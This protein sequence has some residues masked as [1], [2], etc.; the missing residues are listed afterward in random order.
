MLEKKNRILYDKR[1]LEEHTDEAHPATAADIVA[2]LSTIGI[3]AHPRTVV[4][5]IEQLI[6]AGIDVVVNKSR[7][8]QYFIGTRLLQLPEMKL[9]LDAI[10][11]SRF[12]NAKRSRE[13][14]GKLLSLVSQQQAESLRRSLYDDHDA[15]PRSDLA[16]Y[17]VDI[18]L[19]AILNGYRVQ[20][21]YIDYTPQKKRVLR[22]GKRVYE[23]SPVKLVWD[24]DR[25][26]VLGYSKSHDAVATFR[27]DRIASPK[28]MPELEAVPPPEGFD[29]EAYT[30]TVFHM[31]D[32][33][34][35]E[36]TLKCKNDRMISVMDRF[37]EDVKTRVLDPEHFNAYV[38]VNVSNTFYAWVFTWAGSIRITAPKEAVEGYQAMLDAAAESR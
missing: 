9:L 25:Y 18:L 28:L 13:L 7:S 20:F 8:N 2:Y 33:P 36:V 38:R 4:L 34:L 21:N 12:L 29:P 24:S 19:N 17:T 27:V 1:F 32:G 3:S 23:L 6:D 37:G 22:H 16:Y 30:R 11:A 35:M 14:I 10:Q 5:D 31:Y 15:R 26:Y